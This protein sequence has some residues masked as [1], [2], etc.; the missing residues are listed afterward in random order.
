LSK[1][2]DFIEIE[3]EVFMARIKRVDHIGV[4]VRDLDKA[5]ERFESILGAKLI[6]KKEIQITGSRISVA[7]LKLGD[8]IISLDQATDP[9]GFIARFIE[10]RGEGLHHLGLEVDDLDGF[11]EALYKK[12]VKIPHAEDAGGVRSEILLSPKDVCGIVCQ[13]IEWKEGEAETIEERISR[14]NRSLDRWR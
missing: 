3:E 6:R 2:W 12:G 4:A 5:I 1:V 9:N 7:Y 8:S 14:L 10:Q 13:V 11:K